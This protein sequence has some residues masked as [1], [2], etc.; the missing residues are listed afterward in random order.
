MTKGVTRNKKLDISKLKPSTKIKKI[1][2]QYEGYYN[3]MYDSNDP[4]NINL[5]R[6]YRANDGRDWTIG[7]GYKIYGKEG[8]KYKESTIS[9]NE[10]KQFFSD[11]LKKVTEGTLYKYLNKYKVKLYQY[12]YDAL[13]SFT[14]NLG[15]NF[16]NKE[17]E[18]N[19]TIYRLIKRKD[20][21]NKEYVKK[22]FCLYKNPNLLSR[23]K[24]EAKIFN[25][26][27]YPKN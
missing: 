6:N 21:S 26:G 22:V 27:K 23:R 1:I 16:W 25:S 17:K 15:Y 20:Y 2:K 11:D 8:N 24:K 9:K 19:K 3:Y 4:N 13:V 7:W 14:Y 10:A 5:R 12:Q 18:S